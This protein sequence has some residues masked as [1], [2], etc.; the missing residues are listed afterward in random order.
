MLMMM[1]TNDTKMLQIFCHNKTYSK[2]YGGAKILGAHLLHHNFNSS[3]LLRLK[4]F[5]HFQLCTTTTASR[6]HFPLRLRSSHLLL[7]PPFHCCWIEGKTL[8]VWWNSS[9][10]LFHRP[11]FRT[12]PSTECSLP[13]SQ[14]T[15]QIYAKQ[16][17]FFSLCVLMSLLTFMTINRH[18]AS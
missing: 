1:M 15:N 17:T 12:I 13:F 10:H 11:T 14:F 16:L 18:T 4:K 3:Q 2:L 8:F 9:S 7:L 5:Q 6:K